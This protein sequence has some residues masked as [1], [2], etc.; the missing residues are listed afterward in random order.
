MSDEFTAHTDLPGGPNESA[1]SDDMDEFARAMEQLT[2]ADHDVSNQIRPGLIVPGTVVHVDREGVLVDIGAKS[3]GV[4][5]P[6]ELTGVPTQSPEELVKVG[7]RIDVYVLRVNGEDGQIQLSKRRADFDVIWKQMD[8]YMQA[9][10]TIT[11]R[12]RERVKGGL[13]V[14][15]GVRGFVPASQVGTQR[16]RVSD[17]MLDSL[18]G[19]EVPLKV[20]EVDRNKR[21]VVLSHRQAAE[22]LR[23]SQRKELMN[24]ITEGSVLEGTVRRI[25]DYGVFIDLGGVDGLL[26]I[27][28]ISW[29]RIQRPSDVMKEGDKVTVQVLRINP[30]TNKIS[31]GMK[32]LTPDPWIGAEQA[33]YPDQVVHGRVVR[34]APFGA[35]VELEGGLEA[36]IPN[37]ELGPRKVRS[38]ADAVSEGD[39]ISALVLNVNANERRMTL[40]I[41]ALQRK[42]EEREE[43]RNVERYNRSN[44]GSGGYT[45]GEMLR[46]NSSAFMDSVDRRDNG[47]E[48]ESE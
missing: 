4:I 8:E 38:A 40:S 32:Q 34:L 35:I 36:T 14:D 24:T 33:F 27:S 11:G 5:K 1:H 41:R 7:D 30:E 17:A 45:I 12:V 10:E 19:Q 25:V 9:R 44:E 2:P 15:V 16:G 46:K 23:E 3:E 26:H 6:E 39:E 21:K 13:I 47:S 18:V 48:T 37:S 42:L 29:K 22:E 28:E 31:L 20:I 43:S